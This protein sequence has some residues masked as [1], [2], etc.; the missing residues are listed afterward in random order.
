MEKFDESSIIQRIKE[1]Q[2]IKHISNYQ[3]AKDAE[4][5]Y[6]YLN[7][8]LRN[9]HTPSI[10]TLY[11]ICNGLDVSFSYFFEYYTPD[12]YNELFQL[13]SELDENSR[14]TY[15]SY[16]RGALGKPYKKM[17]KGKKGK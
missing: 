3:L 13:W 14:N 5:S 4:I 6:P 12:S 17:E 1:I 11:K 9:T 10:F 16:L 7:S 8:I 2:K 15:L